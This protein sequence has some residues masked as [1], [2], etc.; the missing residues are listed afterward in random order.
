MNQRLKGTG[1]ALVTPFNK[2]GNVDFTSLGKILEHV[3]QG[4]VDYLVVMGTTGESVTLSHDEKFAILDFVKDTVEGRL[5]IVL[6]VGGNNTQEIISTLLETDFEGIEAIL[7]VTPYYNKPQQKG[8]LYHFKDIAGVSPVPVILYNVPGRTGVNM[9]AETTLRLAKEEENI[10]GI[11]EASGNLLQIM[12]IIRNKPDD[13]MVISGDDALTYP[14]I[15]L[16]GQGVISVVANAFPKQFSDIVKLALKG[17]CRKAIAE[18]YR[19]LPLI[20]SLFADGSPSG[21]KAALEIMGLCQ[22]QLRLPLVKVNKQVYQ[23][24][25]TCLESLNS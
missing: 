21:I 22:N 20:N 16:G 2:L 7:S 17:D 6:G 11:K 23:Q 8:L 14:I 13:F 10:I 18:H 24:I 9:T 5:P 1:V 12:E 19:L 15:T 25:Q 3:I 4:G